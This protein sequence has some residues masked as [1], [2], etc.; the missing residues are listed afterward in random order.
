M[1][2]FVSEEIQDKIDK[3]SLC[4]DNV[5]FISCDNKS[6]ATGQIV[7][8]KRNKI[9]IKHTDSFDIKILNL[10]NK[11]IDCSFIYNDVKLSGN[12]YSYSVDEKNNKYIVFN[13][14]ES[15][16]ERN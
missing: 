2:F 5:A 7:L 4:F 3:D 1:S 9:K 6:I 12:I 11:K 13:V 10:I 8:I 16:Y 15:N 14:W